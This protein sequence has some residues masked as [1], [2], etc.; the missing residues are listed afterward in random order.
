MFSL[1]DRAGNVITTAALFVIAATILHV[2]R[3][4][5]LIRISFKKGNPSRWPDI[6]FRPSPNQ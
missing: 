4:A 3:G 2:A 5:F 6:F 1:D